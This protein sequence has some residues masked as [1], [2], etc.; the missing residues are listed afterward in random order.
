MPEARASN[1]PRASES[2]TSMGYPAGIGPATTMP[3]TVSSS[4]SIA[5]PVRLPTSIPVDGSVHTS[6]SLKSQVGC[7]VDGLVH[8][9]VGVANLERGTSGLQ[10]T[11]SDCGAFGA[12]MDA[13]VSAM[14]NGSAPTRPAPMGLPIWHHHSRYNGSVTM[15]SGTHAAAT[16]WHIGY[17]TR[18]ASG[19]C[20][21]DRRLP[22]SIYHSRHL[23]TFHSP[24]GQCLTSL[25]AS[26]CQHR[27]RHLNM[28]RSLRCL[29]VLVSGNLAEHNAP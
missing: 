20:H 10:G 6:V 5:G 21:S 9:A 15:P 19:S 1:L 23:S 24:R 8:I 26:G 17:A 4:V 12:P 3:P 29:S 14:G 7:P 27:S 18:Q 11:S 13:A 16:D 28:R 2:E 22:C 25:R